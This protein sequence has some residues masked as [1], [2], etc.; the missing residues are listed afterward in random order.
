MN[1]VKA[2]RLQAPRQALAL[3]PSVFQLLS[4]DNAMLACGDL[5]DLCVRVRVGD[6]LTHARE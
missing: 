5:R 6:F 4:G 3:E 1:A 2:P